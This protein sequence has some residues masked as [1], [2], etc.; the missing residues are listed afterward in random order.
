MFKPQGKLKIWPKSQVRP[1]RYS[2]PSFQS[3][4]STHKIKTWNHFTNHLP[5]Y[6]KQSQHNWNPRINTASEY[7]RFQIYSTTAIR[8]HINKKIKRE[9]EKWPSRIEQ[10]DHGPVSKW[11]QW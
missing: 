1:A 2:N 7:A 6:Q 8:P 4:V 10:V 9:E 11:V 3:L 5:H